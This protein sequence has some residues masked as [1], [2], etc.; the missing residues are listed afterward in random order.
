[1]LNSIDE[2]IIELEDMQQ[3][4]ELVNSTE[5]PIII[6]CYADWCQP[7]KKLTPMLEKKVL[8]SENKLRLVKVNIDTHPQIASAFK[9]QSI[10][11]VFLVNRGQVVDMF[12]GMVDEKK[13]E[14]FVNTAKA[15]EMLGHDQRV[16]GNLLKTADEAAVNGEYGKARKIYEEAYSYEK[17]RGQLGAHISIGLAYCFVHGLQDLSSTKHHLAKYDQHKKTSDALSESIIDMLNQTNAELSKLESLEKPDEK[18]KELMNKCDTDP[19]D[20]QSRFELAKYLFEE[21]S[22]ADEAI[23]WCLEIIA[24]DR[25]WNEKAAYNMLIKIFGQLGNSNEAVKAGRKKLTKLL[26]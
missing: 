14:E 9:V 23:D 11:A 16:V 2:T 7:C 25:N 24:I 4:T 18:E 15:M 17:W 3:F 21:R 5:T 6:D 10:P 12:S 26:F 20:L 1:M 13:L 8:E 19:K 22:K